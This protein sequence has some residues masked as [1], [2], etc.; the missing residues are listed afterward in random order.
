MTW[1]DVIAKP[2]LLVRIGNW[3]KS[4]VS[5]TGENWSFLVSKVTDNKSV[6]ET[7]IKAGSKQE[8]NIDSILRGKMD[9]LAKA[10][11]WTDPTWPA[12]IKLAKTE[13]KNLVNADTM[14]KYIVSDDYKA[15]LYEAK[16]TAAMDKL[17]KAIK[18]LGI[19]ESVAK[20]MIPAISLYHETTNS[21]TKTLAL[22]AMNTAA[23]V[24]VSEDHAR[25]MMAALKSAG[26]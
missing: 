2:A 11:K 24:A 1:D 3:M 9:V 17:K 20:S 19:S 14:R 7:F 15:Y 5:L 21:T 18:V 25:I 6:Y 10:G 23:K 8:V 16:L 26:L 22:R 13:V 12:L 4:P